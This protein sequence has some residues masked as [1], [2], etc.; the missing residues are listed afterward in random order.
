[1]TQIQINLDE[2]EDKILSIYRTLGKFD[3]KEKALKTMIKKFK[4]YVEKK[5]QDA[6]K[7]N[8]GEDK[9]KN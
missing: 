4:G 1:M 9:D 6:F 8:N 5:A 3:S 2:E 7:T